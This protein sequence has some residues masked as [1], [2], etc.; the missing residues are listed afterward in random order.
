MAHLALAVSLLLA[1]TSAPRSKTPHAK[2]RVQAEAPAKAFPFP[3]E[4]HSLKNGLRVVFVPCDS[5]GLVAYYT[6]MRVGSR[7]EPESGR[8][9][10]AHFFEHMM[11]RGT[12]AHPAE[13]YN[14]TVTRLGL[15]TNAFTD[16][17][18]T[19][20]HL[21][22]P[23]KALPTIIDYEADRFQNLDYSEAQFKTEA[24]AILGEYAK[25]ASNPGEKLYERMLETAY[26][27]HTYRHTVIGYLDD[28]KAM[29]GGFEYSR[30]FFKRYYT[31]DNATIVIA[32]DFD[33]AA[34]LE[35]ITKA[36][37][38]WKGKLNPAKIPVEPRQ[39]AGR[40][41]TVWWDVPTLP[42][43]WLAWHAPSSN[44]LK[45]AAAQDLL[46]GYL[47]G[48]TS[49][50]YQE[51]VL[52]KQTVDALEPSWYDHRDP[53]LFGVIARVKKIGDVPSVEDAITAE[54]RKL[55]AG[56][57][58][59]A[60]LDAVRS[61]LKYSNILGLD[62]ADSLAVTLATSTALT[63]KI[64]YINQLYAQT[65]T[66]RP[67][68]LVAFA[69]KYLTDANRT[70]VTLATG[71]TSAPDASPPRKATRAAAAATKTRLTGGAK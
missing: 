42:R 51:L 69:K 28:I 29:P 61:N 55:A 30:Q 33:K 9:G 6:L 23:S 45:A 12:K 36:Y 50:L 59:V 1:L 52:N 8:S 58:D 21:Y 60:R 57:V 4:L 65:D 27:K 62:T 7:N 56:Q 18:M 26:D 11:F 5:P 3:T 70:T 68:E 64:E 49:A 43:L 10:Y 53:F 37:S 14:D 40:R 16:F 35:E 2:A 25:S 20:F 46:N 54:V 63:G 39:T 32:G 44:D 41:A 13:E 22:G 48:P 66:L 15:S 24:G 38:G 19:V 34:A 31:P 67:A 71:T 47:F 17:D